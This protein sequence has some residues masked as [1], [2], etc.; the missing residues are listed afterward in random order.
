MKNSLILAVILA[1]MSSFAQTSEEALKAGEVNRIKCDT[2]SDVFKNTFSG[3]IK[4]QT[5]SDEVVF[6]DVVLATFSQE[7]DSKDLIVLEEMHGT[8]QLIGAGLLDKGDVT[9]VTLLSQEDSEV[10]AYLVI[11]LGMKGMNSRLT[12]DS[13]AIYSSSCSVVK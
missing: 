1:S 9:S 11:N 7:N 4:L 6:A 5:Q 12:V 13:K 2:I 8:Q 10:R 3:E